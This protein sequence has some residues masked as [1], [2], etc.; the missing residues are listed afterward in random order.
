MIKK[1]IFTCLLIA[2]YLLT[3]AQNKI[4][5]HP[6]VQAVYRLFADARINIKDSLTIYALNF[7]LNIVKK[8][9]KTIVTSISANDSLAYTLFPFYKKL[10]AIDFSLIIGEKKNV[11]LIIPIMIYGSSPEKMIN[12]DKNNNPLI[13]FN[14]AVNAAYALYNPFKYNNNK[15]AEVPIG[16]LRF[17]ATKER[18]PQREFWE[19]I[20]MEPLLIQIHNIK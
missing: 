7:E 3:F 15:D 5:E 2:M 16:H 9:N 17:K 20:T 6:P 18:K 10:S 12:K 4:V 14:A 1:L 11:R 8:Q 19:A 13:S